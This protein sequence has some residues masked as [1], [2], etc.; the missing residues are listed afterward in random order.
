MPVGGRGSQKGSPLSAQ[1]FS[2]LGDLQVR[3]S[4]CRWEAAEMSIEVAEVVDQK[5]QVSKYRSIEVAKYQVFT[6]PSVEFH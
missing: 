4:S 5:Y 3:C 1:T 6:Y 2:F